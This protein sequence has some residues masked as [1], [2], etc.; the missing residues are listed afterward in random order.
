LRIQELVELFKSAGWGGTIERDVESSLAKVSS[1]K[2]F[3]CGYNG[4]FRPV[5]PEVCKWHQNSK[6]PECEKCVRVRGF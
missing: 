5:H 6:D 4:Q 2:P 3:W 1:R